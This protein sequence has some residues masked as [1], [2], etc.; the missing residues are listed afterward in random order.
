MRPFLYGAVLAALAAPIA[1]AADIGE[2]HLVAHETSAAFR[3]AANRDYVNL[4]V[5]YPAAPDAA[6]TPVDLV[7]PGQRVSGPLGPV[8]DAPFIDRR[9]HATILLSPGFG[10][11]AGSMAWFGTA[12][13]RHGYIVVAVDPPGNNGR[14]PVTVGGAVLFWERPRDLAA[15]LAKVEDDAVVGAHVNRGQIGVAG[16]SAGG[17]AS[18]AAAKARIDLRH[19]K[20]FCTTHPGDTFCAP[21][22]VLGF[23]RAEA[24][25]FIAQPEIAREIR[26]A[27]DDMTIAGVKAAYVMA[28]ALVQ[29]LDFGSLH[30]LRAPV[31]IILGAADRV[32]PPSTNGE[33]AAAAIPGAKLRILRGV[34]HY[35][36]VADCAEAG[37]ASLDVCATGVPRAETHDIVT[38]DALG[39]FDATL[40]GS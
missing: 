5:W 35:D 25:N 17:L 27:R 37:D 16:F 9:R 40:R 34:G 15:A 28:P 38:G 13:A 18:L 36:F 2:R 26:H 19:Y 31:R 30:S 24:D 1:S 33:Q 29:S 22:T 4:T 32:S 12:L 23:T 39:F 8:A 11:S 20:A 21:E 7:P 3:D 14:E 10:G 6:E